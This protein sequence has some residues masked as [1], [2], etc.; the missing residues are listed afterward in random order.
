M[1]TKIEWKEGQS[2]EKGALVAE[3]DSRSTV[4]KSK[5]AEAEYYAVPKRKSKTIAEIEVAEK[6]VEVSKAE[7]HQ[8]KEIRKKNPVP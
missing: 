6:A 5:I 7:L 2:V 1:I 8:S 4:A 3:I